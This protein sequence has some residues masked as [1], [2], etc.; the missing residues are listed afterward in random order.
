MGRTLEQA[1]NETFEHRYDPLGVSPEALQRG[2]DPVVSRERSFI[3]RYAEGEMGV[4]AL[5]RVGVNDQYVAVLYRAMGVRERD[6]RLDA[7]RLGDVLDVKESGGDRE[8]SMLVD[9]VE[10]VEDPERVPQVVGP[11]L[12]TVVRLFALN[13]VKRSFRQLRESVSAKSALEKV[14]TDRRLP[15]LVFVPDHGIHEGL[16]KFGGQRERKVTLRERINHV[17]QSGTEILDRIPGDSTDLLGR[18]RLDLRPSNCVP[19][20]GIYLT[21]DGVGIR[22]EPVIDQMLDA[23]YVLAC[24]RQFGLSA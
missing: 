16:L 12:V 23:S 10:V 24:T 19:R 1:L 22:P 11:G 17:I 7:S 6:L 14:R 2:V 13:E 9:A 21:T 8:P 18:T 3:E 20:L 4:Y 5:V 15:L